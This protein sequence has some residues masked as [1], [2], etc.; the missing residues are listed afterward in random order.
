MRISNGDR[1]NNFENTWVRGDSLIIFG[2]GY[3]DNAYLLRF[4]IQPYISD[5]SENTE[6]CVPTVSWLTL[7][8][9]LP[10]LISFRL[11]N[12]QKNCIFGH[13]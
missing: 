6:W 12:V 2:L 7:L 4:P 10:I 13:L 1:F 9:L 3:A 8:T 11:V 5:S